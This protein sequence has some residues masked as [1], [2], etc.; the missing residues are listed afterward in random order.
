VADPLLDLCSDPFVVREGQKIRIAD[1]EVAA[2]SIDFYDVLP[3]Q[4][5]VTAAPTNHTDTP[6]GVACKF[7]GDAVS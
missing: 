3:I 6:A 1:F 7:C 2:V 5:A 4:F